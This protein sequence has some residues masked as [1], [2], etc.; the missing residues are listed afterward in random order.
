MDGCGNLVV[1]GQPVLHL[2]S[3]AYVLFQRWLEP[4]ALVERDSGRVRLKDPEQKLPD[5][6]V[7]AMFSRQQVLDQSL[8]KP[9][10][11]KFGSNPDRLDVTTGPRL[12]FVLQRIRAFGYHNADD[13]A[14]ALCY[15][16]GRGPYLGYPIPH[17]DVLERHEEG[18]G[19][20]ANGL[21][22]HVMQNLR[23]AA[24]PGGFT[25]AIRHTAPPCLATTT[26][27]LQHQDN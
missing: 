9:K 10:P 22:Q 19:R 25:P 18:L 1:E 17:V 27:V 4:Y 26:T 15:H 21:K 2:S 20:D 6:P 12:L 13:L 8:P 5:V 11:A 24:E 7:L 3:C 23:V 14:V 16:P